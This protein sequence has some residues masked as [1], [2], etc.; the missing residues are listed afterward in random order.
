MKIVLIDNAVDSL[1][2]AMNAF[3]LW[4]QEFESRKDVRYLKITIE[5]LHN[6]V[7]LLM[8]AILSQYDEKSIYCSAFILK[9][10]IIH[11]RMAFS[12]QQM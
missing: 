10:T 4:N 3:E 12:T 1:Q 5:F 7:E 9:I 11:V 8:K 2:I 6:T